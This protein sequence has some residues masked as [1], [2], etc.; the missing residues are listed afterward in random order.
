[1][2]AGGEEERSKEVKVLAKFRLSSLNIIK[3]KITCFLHSLN[4]IN[5]L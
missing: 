2:E 1:M 4:L 3:S 5:I